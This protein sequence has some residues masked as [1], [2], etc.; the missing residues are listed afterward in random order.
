M[1]MYIDIY[2]CVYVYRYIYVCVC[3]NPTGLQPKY[4]YRRHGHTCYPRIEHAAAGGTL[5]NMVPRASPN[6]NL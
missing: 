5:V 6:E 1:Y 2:I 3:F 4:G